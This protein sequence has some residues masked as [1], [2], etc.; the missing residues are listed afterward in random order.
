[1]FLLSLALL[2]RPRRPLELLLVLAATLS[3][4]IAFAVE[5]AN[6]DVL[7][8]MMVLGAAL[9]AQGRLGARLLGYSVAALA[10]M[11]KY[12]P[13]MA[14]IIVFRERTDRFIAVILVLMVSFFTFGLMYS[15]EIA[16]GLPTIAHGAYTTDLFAAGNL[17]FALA[18]LTRNA[19]ARWPWAQ[20]AGKVSGTL[21]Y[22]LLVASGVA[23]CRRLLRLGEFRDA[24]DRL[25]ER[26]GI[27]LVVGSAVIAGCFFAGQSIGYRGVYFLL[28]LPGFLAAAGSAA[29]PVVRRLLLCTGVV[30][31]LLMWEE[32]F[33]LALYHWLAHADLS[34]AAIFK[35]KIAFFCARELAWWWV[36]SIVVAILA[37]FL[38]RSEIL[39]ERGSL[40]RGPA[41]S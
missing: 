6:P 37:D 16:E 38:L 10:A 4:M 9:L 21:I 40:L 22:L 35:L 39:R 34:E 2:P 8:F 11:M 13:I 33:R 14:L 12:Y 23:I 17:P 25:D 18:G 28:V 3:T 15:K 32:C 19:A 29:D 30:I 5:R 24:F 27:S 20:F 1:L 26:R 7:L 31:V 36:V 41:T